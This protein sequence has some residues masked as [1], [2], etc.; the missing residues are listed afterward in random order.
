M[1]HK[2]YVSVFSLYKVNWSGESNME[3]CIGH[4]TKTTRA[5]NLVRAHDDFIAVLYSSLFC[6][7]TQLTLGSID[8]KK[9][10]HPLNYYSF[11]D[12]FQVKGEE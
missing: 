10:L 2:D 6:L 4:I 7:V 1:K 9:Q 11:N 5:Q 8:V 12:T 3:E